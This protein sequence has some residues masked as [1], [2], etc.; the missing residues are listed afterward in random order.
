MPEVNEKY[1]AEI[2]ADNQNRIVAERK[3]FRSMFPDNSSCKYRGKHGCAS[4]QTTE[5]IGKCLNVWGQR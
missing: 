1:S 3:R 4:C 2:L 5:P